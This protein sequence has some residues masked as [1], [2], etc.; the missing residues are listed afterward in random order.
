MSWWYQF[1]EL[2]HIEGYV[3]MVYCITNTTNDKKYIGKKLFKFTR[4]KKP[5]KGKTR[6]RKV[7]IDSDW[8]EYFG[9]NA[10]L[11]DDVAKLGEDKFTREVLHLCE[12]KGMCN[13]LEAR[14]Q[15]ERK[16]L[17][18]DQYYNTWIMVKVHKK[19]V[20]A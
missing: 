4:T 14:E 2:E 18:S 13:Y 11:L 17:E 12:T 6:K 3:G 15:M 8:R 7:K 1:K 20:R 10:E 19:H 9:S 5:L 16:V